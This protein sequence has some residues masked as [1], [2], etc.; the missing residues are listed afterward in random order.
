MHSHNPPHH[1]LNL[2]FHL[3]YAS[4]H[5]RDHDDCQTNQ[6]VHMVWLLYQ[7][8]FDLEIDVHLKK[9]RMRHNDNVINCRNTSLD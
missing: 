3:G 1:T 4:N 6:T 8:M 5:L 9:T 7:H 2:D